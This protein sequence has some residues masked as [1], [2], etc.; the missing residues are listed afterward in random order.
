MSDAPKKT[1]SPVERIIVWGLI[2]LMLVVVGIEYRAK[3][4]YDKALNV[5]SEMGKPTFGELKAAVSGATVGEPQENDFKVL[6]VPFK[7]FS[8]F[9][10]YRMMAQLSDAAEGT[11]MDDRKV[12]EFYTPVALEDE[13]DKAQI[14][15][16]VV[17]EGGATL[18]S[19]PS[20]GAGAGG[21][22]GNRQRRPEPEAD[23]NDTDAGEN[24]DADEA[25][26]SDATPD[27]DA[28]EETEEGDK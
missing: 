7:F 26:E 18:P 4:N 21:G 17:P 12:A 5:F 6:E 9:K 23:A 2:L 16:V 28:G 22:S 19:P 15:P 14:I 27:S 11:A 1:R 10:D 3:T 25:T 24:T 13:Q 20:G 8:F